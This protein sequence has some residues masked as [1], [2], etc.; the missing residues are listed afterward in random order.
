MASAYL[1]RAMNGNSETIGTIS[2]WLKR[3][4]LGQSVI[5]SFWEDSTTYQRL[6]FDSNDRLHWSI[7]DNNND[8]GQIISTRK[9][10][11]TNA[12]Y[13]IVSRVDTTQSTAADRVRL[14]VNG[15]LLDT[16]DSGTSQPTQNRNVKQ[17]A[18]PYIGSEGTIASARF[19]GCMTHVHYTDAASNAPTVFGETDATTGEWKIKTDVST[20][21]GAKGF[22]ILKDGNS[23]TDHSGNSNTFTVSGTLT[24]MVD[25]P[26]NI[27]NCWNRLNRGSVSGIQANG[28]GNV[29]SYI[30]T[31]ASNEHRSF[32]STLAFP[33]TGK[34]YT[35][36]KVGNVGGGVAIGIG[37]VDAMSNCLN[38]GVAAFFAN[39]KGY[40]YESN[41]NKQS[42]GSSSSYGNTYTSYDYMGLAYN[43]G[44]LWF[45][46]NGTWQNS[47]TASEIAAGTTTNA[48][49]TGIDTS[50]Q[51]F[52]MFN[53]YNDGMIELNSGNGYFRA[54]V[55][56]SNNPSS[57]DTAA[58]FKYAVPTGLQPIST[59]GMNT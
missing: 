6:Q 7:Y 32:G 1:T 39:A 8:Y 26:S 22:F 20:T 48:A 47:A 14:Y 43:N 37:E 55:A 10:R 18:V 2:L 50:K 12:W 34:F 51:Y 49:F 42:G 28:F 52:V 27:Y 56:G 25:S 30:A 59:K 3:T 38:S 15:E 35:E 23:G 29:G 11:D 31:T 45:S 53:G 9:F 5:C 21:Y 4:N 33:G 58:K 19:D 24:D 40:G 36:F 41:G 16:F 44:A 13:H 17:S 57:G 54:A 46:K